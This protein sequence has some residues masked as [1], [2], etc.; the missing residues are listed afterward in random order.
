MR[1]AANPAFSGIACRPRFSL[2]LGKW[3]EGKPLESL[4]ECLKRRQTQKM[5]PVS[6]K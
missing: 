2:R 6:I 1:Q 4:Q 5:R 3:A